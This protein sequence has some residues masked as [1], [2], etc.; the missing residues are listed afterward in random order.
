M[1]I[2]R[3]ALLRKLLGSSR[4][5]VAVVLFSLLILLSNRTISAE[6]KEQAT[7]EVDMQIVWSVIHDQGAQIFFSNY[8]E[9]NWTV[10]VQISDS[11]NF[12]SQPVS[13]IGN[14]GKIWALWTQKGKNGDF[15]QFSVCSKSRWS[16][17]KKIKTGMNNNR[18]VTVIVANNNIPW[19]AWTATGDSYTDVFWSR[20]NGQEWDVPVKAHADN[21]VPDFDPDLVLDDSGRIILSWQTFDNDEYISVSKILDGQQGQSIPYYSAKKIIKKIFPE[22]NIK[23]MIPEFIKE[24]HQATLFIKRHDGAGSIPLTNF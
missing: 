4:E 7:Q 24:R 16:L 5:P 8:K 6:A 23:A 14:D 20:W 15:L 19:I 11:D 10:P 22:D 13:S 9:N 18:A 17:P 2:G 21:R 3:G 1:M 12:V